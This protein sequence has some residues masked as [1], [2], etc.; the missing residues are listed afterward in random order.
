MKN[1]IISCVVIL[2]LVGCYAFAQKPTEFSSKTAN[3]A[4]INAKFD[5]PAEGKNSKNGGGYSANVD[6]LN[7]KPKKVA[8]ISFYLY[9]P[10][11]GKSSSTAAVAATGKSKAEVWRTSDALAQIHVNGFYD[12]SIE[13]L[14]AGFKEYG[15]EL[16][17][18]DQFLDTEDK[19]GFY[20]GFDPESGKKERT[21]AR[22][23][24]Y[25]VSASISNI[26]VCPSDK[27]YRPLFV[28]NEPINASAGANFVNTGIG[29]ANR[30]MTSSYGYD[31]CKEL[32]VDAVVVCYIVTRKP[33]KKKDD[34]VVDAVSLY[35]FGSN[36]KSEGP[37]D[38]NRGQ[39]YCGTRFLAKQSEFSNA[40]SG[41]TSYDNMGNVMLALSKRMGNWVINK[42]KK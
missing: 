3:A 29:G 7:P 26:K 37:D 12:N 8:L 18:P 5:F 41:V 42:A 2:M 24:G 14:K 32:G 19:K 15:M 33:K 40:K 9:D 20:Y 16:L 27:G 39:F 21:T 36:P 23:I 13:S 28:V 11:C 1:K 25:Y 30:K 10:A 31:L 17:T 6:L 38:K 35:M 34:F 22:S 4:K